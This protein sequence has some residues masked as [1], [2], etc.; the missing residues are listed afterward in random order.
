MPN[1]GI[2][3]ALGI[4]EGSGD[5]VTLKA[6]ADNALGIDAKNNVYI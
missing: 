6:I 3:L 1:S 4:S 2:S 5:K